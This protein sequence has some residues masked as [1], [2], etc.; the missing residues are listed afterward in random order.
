M[1]NDQAK[2]DAEK[3]TLLKKVEDAEAA[4]K[5]V[6]EELSALKHQINAMTAAIFGK[7]LR[8][9]L[10]RNLYVTICRF[11]DLLRYYRNSHK[12]SWFRHEAEVEG[13]L[14]LGGTIVLRCPAGYLCHCL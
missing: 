7:C 12:P 10:C 8:R 2:W 9:Y 11:T 3:E 1:K 4:L 14:Y 5:P 13:D 6:A